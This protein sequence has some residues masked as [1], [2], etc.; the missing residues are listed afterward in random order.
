MRH[1]IKISFVTLPSPI[2]RRHRGI[3]RT[4]SQAF[5]EC[6]SERETLHIPNSLAAV[7]RL[8]C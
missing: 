7:V 8:C 6:G 1:A 4:R 5:A 3:L 2:S